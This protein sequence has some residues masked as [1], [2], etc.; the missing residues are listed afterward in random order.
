MKQQEI[1]HAAFLMGFEPS[2]DGLSE[3][4]IFEE[5]SDFIYQ[6]ALNQL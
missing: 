5:A 3:E 6:Y 2:S 4:Q 1:I